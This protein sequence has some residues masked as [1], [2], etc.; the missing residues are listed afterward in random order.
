VLKNAQRDAK[1]LK[2][3]YY[4]DEIMIKTPGNRSIHLL[5]ITSSD[6]K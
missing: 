1:L 4:K 5:T 3:V 6:E 2:A